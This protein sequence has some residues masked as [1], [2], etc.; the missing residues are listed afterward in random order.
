M[1][2]AVLTSGVAEGIEE[3]EEAFPG[4]VEHEPDGAGGAYVTVA[5]IPTGGEVGPR[6]G[7]AQFSPSLQLSECG[8]LPLL[9]ARR[10]RPDRAVAAGAAKSP[11]A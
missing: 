3:L 7:A 5:D 9:P 2:E 11:L 1:T 10:H 8:A 4:R 6:L